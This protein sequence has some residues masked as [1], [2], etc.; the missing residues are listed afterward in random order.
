MKKL[1]QDFPI[2]LE[3]A[4]SIGGNYKFT[5]KKKAFANIVL[6]GL[7]GSGIGGSIVQNFLFDKLN[8]PFVVNK[9]YFLPAFVNENSLGDR[10]FLFRK[11]RGNLAGDETSFES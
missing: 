5:T 10:I 9:D 1:I 4:L 8:I 11:Y 7:G 6:T 2:Q 3:E